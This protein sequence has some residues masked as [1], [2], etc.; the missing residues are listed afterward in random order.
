MDIRDIVIICLAVSNAVGWGLYAK[1][2]IDLGSR[3]RLAL[4]KRD[5]DRTKRM[6]D[7]VEADNGD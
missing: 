4:F 3:A 2:M 7:S 5:V 1:E 6:V